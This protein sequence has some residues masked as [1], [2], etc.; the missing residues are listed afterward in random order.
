M[1]DILNAATYE[2]FADYS[3]IPEEGKYFNP[4]ILEKNNI[5]F[6]KTDHINYLF[7]NLYD[8]KNE[9]VLITHHSDY[10]IDYNRFSTKPQ[11]IKKWFAQNGIYD[12][13]I[14]EPI[15]IGLKTDK[16]IFVEK[17]NNGEILYDIEWFNEKKEILKNNNKKETFYCNWNITNSNRNNIINVISHLNLTIESNLSYKNYII[18]MSKC[19][20]VISPPGNGIDCHRTWEALYLGCIPIVIKH[21][22]YDNWNDLPILQVN[23][24]NEITNE[25][26]ENFSKKEFNYEKLTPTYWEQ[27]IKSNINND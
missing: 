27:K 8:S 7:N 17:N 14:L 6:C 21:N 10:P 22:L 5:I 2:F 9:Y 16:G 25:I 12:N 19:K 20:Y 24:Y 18:N 11:C 3:I 4:N 13:Q 1:L 23:D 15:P 26:L